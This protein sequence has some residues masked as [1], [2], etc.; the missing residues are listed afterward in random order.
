MSVSLLS[1]TFFTATHSSPSW[2]RKTTPCA[3]L[4]T[5][6]KLLMLSKGISQL[7]P[8]PLRSSALAV[9]RMLQ[10]GRRQPRSPSNHPP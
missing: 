1:V 9:L 4:P 2:P 6:L 8:C 7:S 10:T 3:P 5:N